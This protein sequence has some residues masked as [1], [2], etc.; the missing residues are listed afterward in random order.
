MEK[1]KLFFMSSEYIRQWNEY[2]VF[3][4]VYSNSVFLF[5]R[6]TCNIEKVFQINSESV[7]ENLY[8]D[9]M[10]Y[11]NE[12]LLIPYAANDF[13][14]INLRSEERKVISTM[15]EE[16]QRNIDAKFLFG[17]V[18]NGILWCIGKEL[19]VVCCYDIKQKY[20]KIKEKIFSKEII[21]SD[22]YAINENKVYIPSMNKN[23][24]LII[25]TYTYEIKIEKIIKESVREG[26]LDIAYQ[27]ETLYLW[28]ELGEEYHLD[29]KNQSIK[30]QCLSA[31]EIIASRQSFVYKNRIFR[32]ALFEDSIIKYDLKNEKRSKIPIAVKNSF[33]TEMTHFHH[34]ILDGNIYWLQT[35]FGQ[36]FQINMDDIS[37][38][39]IDMAITNDLESK[40]VKRKYWNQK[41]KEEVIWE[42]K[43]GGIFDLQEYICEIV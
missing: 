21:W 15:L 20:K 24:I 6:K 23:L 27:Q 3:V 39:K 37:L 31:K 9:F 43:Y 30:K 17:I 5:N 34:G 41:M 18:I 38:K 10:I 22:A 7:K 28:D 36:L 32:I 25:N 35:R 13:I 40:I 33:N 1:N 4:S 19:H 8:R 11:E 29:I 16:D 26:F 12:L 42:F 14:S 2:L